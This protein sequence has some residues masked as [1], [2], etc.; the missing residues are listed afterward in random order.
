[1]GEEL[2]LSVVVKGTNIMSNPLLVAHGIA[3]LKRKAK[4]R[5]IHIETPITS[6]ETFVDLFEEL[7]NADPAEV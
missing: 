7:F 6:V 5:T 1:M 4:P 2:V 3:K